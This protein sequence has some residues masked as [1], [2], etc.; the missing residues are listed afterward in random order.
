MATA[1]ASPRAAL[2]G[3]MVMVLPLSPT[4]LWR[5]NKGLAMAS[6]AA[7]QSAFLRRSRG[8]SM[9]TRPRYAS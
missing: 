8:V 9:P 5:E 6:P 3:D 2:L 1:A 4:A 7:A